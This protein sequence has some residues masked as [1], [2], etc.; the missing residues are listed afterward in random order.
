MN[1][2]MKVNTD[3]FFAVVFRK[4]K[5]D[6]LG[7]FV[8]KPIDVVVGK[9]IDD[10]EKKMFI[11]EEEKQYLF[12]D[13][14]ELMNANVRYVVGDIYPKA[15]LTA[16]F[17]GQLDEEQM[18]DYLFQQAFGRL[19]FGMY[20]EAFNKVELSAVNLNE[21]YN[22]M[23]LKNLEKERPEEFQALILEEEKKYLKNK[24]GF[25]NFGKQD[26]VDPFKKKNTIGFISEPKLSEEEEAKR[27][28]QKVK[29][30]FQLPNDKR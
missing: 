3:E 16:L 25:N 27:P 9:F 6:D 26:L 22:N 14:A 4:I 10:N 8:F 13:D 23:Y 21:S 19:N 11:D 15:L 30:G 28:K 24:I 1:E 20:I 7:L 18:K 17:Q 5:M 29:I 12:T 2:D